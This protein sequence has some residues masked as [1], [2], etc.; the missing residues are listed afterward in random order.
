MNRIG[1]LNRTLVHPKP[2]P[3]RPKR[4]L[5]EAPY[6]G[7]RG[8]GGKAMVIGGGPGDGGTEV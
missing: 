6:V 7:G 8:K 4:P 1:M 3:S 2:G 5:L